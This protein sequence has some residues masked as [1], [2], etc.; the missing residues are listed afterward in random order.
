M[1]RIRSSA[2]TSKGSRCLAIAF[3]RRRPSSVGRDD[4]NSRAESGDLGLASQSLGTAL[5]A[6]PHIEPDTLGVREY[7]LVPA[8]E[9][10]DVRWL[11]RCSRGRVEFSDYLAGQ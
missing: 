6:W 9:R 10:R 1:G 11:R 2:A 3:F 5:N 4:E 7:R 8:R